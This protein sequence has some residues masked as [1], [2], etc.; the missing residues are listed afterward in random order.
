MSTANT[1]QPHQ[2]WTHQ[3]LHGSTLLPRPSTLKFVNIP[4]VSGASLRLTFGPPPPHQ[5]WGHA[6][7]EG[8]YTGRNRERNCHILRISPTPAFCTKAKV[9]KGGK[10]IFAGHYGNSYTAT[11]TTH[12]SSVVLCPLHSPAVSQVGSET[13]Q[14][15]PAE[16]QTLA[17]C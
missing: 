3:L 14:C 8:S 5:W 1:D 12:H 11:D 9:E 16:H 10:G 2:R 17:R 7:P 6:L 15:S 4:L 13:V